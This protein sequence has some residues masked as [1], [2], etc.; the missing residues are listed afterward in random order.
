MSLFADSIPSTVTLSNPVKVDLELDDEPTGTMILMPGTYS[1]S[2][3]EPNN[4]GTGWLT[5]FLPFYD[6]TRDLT[7]TAQLEDVVDAVYEYKSI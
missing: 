1:V 5:M 4:D 6:D 7:A 2:E 3:Y